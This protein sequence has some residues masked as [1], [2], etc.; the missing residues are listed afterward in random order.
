M[1]T[2]K[3]FKKPVAARVIDR[4]STI[5][6]GK[7]NERTHMTRAPRIASFLS[8]SINQQN[9]I[10]VF[11]LVALSLSYISAVA[12]QNAPLDWDAGCCGRSFWWSP[13]GCSLILV[14]AAFFFR[15]RRW[16]SWIS[17]TLL[18][19]YVSYY[20]LYEAIESWKFYFSL[21]KM[22]ALRAAFLPL[23]RPLSGFVGFY[24]FVIAAGKLVRASK[25]AQIQARN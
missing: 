15:V 17:V 10:L 25:H 20:S 12:D 9:V 1:S 23:Y 4:V 7:F 11:S 6:M 14:G 5:P 19:G 21:D 18:S 16:W 8:G 24:I 3:R 2:T 22:E 13:V